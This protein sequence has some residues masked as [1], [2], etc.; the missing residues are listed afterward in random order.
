MGRAIF[1]LVALAV[2]APG[3]ATSFNQDPVTLTDEQ[4]LQIVMRESRMTVPV[5]IANA[6]PWPFIIDTGAQ[7]TVISRELANVLKLERGRDVML[8]AMTGRSQVRTAVIPNLRVS[9][10]GGE[11]IEAPALAARHLGATGMLGIDSLQ[12]H[13][14]SID[15]ERKTMSVLRSEKRSR[16]LPASPDEVVVTARDYLGQLVVTNAEY[17]GRAIRIVL[18]TGTPVSIGNEALRKLAARGSGQPIEL[19]SVV[20]DKMDVGYTQLKSVKFGGLELQNLP[21]AFAAAAPFRQFKLEKRPALLLGM[22]A[23]GLFRRVDIDFPNREL[24]LLKP[25]GA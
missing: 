8:T 1:A 11:K 6:G 13:K 10:L 9:V 25:R 12:G 22:D 19:T 16:R 5:N 14:V 24:R 3:A 2:A 15:F 4:V 21:V 23:L 7:R 17:K 18:D 20:G